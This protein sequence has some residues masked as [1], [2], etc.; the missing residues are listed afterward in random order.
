MARLL[1]PFIVGLGLGFFV[2]KALFSGRRSEPSDWEAKYRDLYER[3]RELT[4]TLKQPADPLPPEYARLRQ[5][6]WDV[7]DLLSGRDGL[8]AEETRSVLA[9][10][11]ELFE[12]TRLRGDG[13]A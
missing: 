5:G 7:R 13:T 11:D 6:L 4:R 9:R 3:Y 8:S 10:V 1:L 2:G 12:S